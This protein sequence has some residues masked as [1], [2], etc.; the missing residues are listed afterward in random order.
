[1]VVVVV[2]VVVGKG[3]NARRFKVE[4]LSQFL[5]FEAGKAVSDF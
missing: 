3:E 4:F 5:R 1:V 2:V